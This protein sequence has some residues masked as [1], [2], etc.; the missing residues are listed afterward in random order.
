MRVDDVYDLE[1]IVGND[2]PWAGKFLGYTSGP[3][4]SGGFLF[5]YDG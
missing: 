3:V 5:F 1:V 4:A 2:A